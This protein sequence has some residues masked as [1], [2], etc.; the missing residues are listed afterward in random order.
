MKGRGAEKGHSILKIL[1]MQHRII[2]PATFKKPADGNQQSPGHERDKYRSAPDDT[3][4]ALEVIQ[5]TPPMI[6]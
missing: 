4:A 6:K 5:V 1:N 3:Q 2:N